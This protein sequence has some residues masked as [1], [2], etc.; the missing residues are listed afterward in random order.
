[1]TAQEDDGRGVGWLRGVLGMGWLM[2]GWLVRGEGGELGRGRQRVGFGL[3]GGV[4]GEMG[5]L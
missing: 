2:V 3:R 1:V 4:G 5:V